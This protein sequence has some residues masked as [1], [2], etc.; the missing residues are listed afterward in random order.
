MMNPAIN[1]IM[2]KLK[3]YLASCLNRASSIMYVMF[4]F[5][6]LSNLSF[7]LS[8]VSNNS[9]LGVKALA[10]YN[11]NYKK[12]R[13]RPYTLQLFFTTPKIFSTVLYMGNDFRNDFF[14]KIVV[15]IF[16]VCEGLKRDY[17]GDKNI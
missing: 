11:G 2:L 7:L 15:K 9:F 6:C 12:S 3:R 14:G 17:V 4:Q 8:T 16:V 5:F 13:C 1:R 10:H